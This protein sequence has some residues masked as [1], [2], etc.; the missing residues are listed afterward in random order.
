[1]VDYKSACSRLGLTLP[2]HFQLRC[3][4]ICRHIEDMIGPLKY[5]KIYIADAYLFKTALDGAQAGR[6]SICL[7][8]T[9][10]KPRSSFHLPSI[11]VINNEDV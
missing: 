7:G 5:I 6:D 11:S 1:M 2:M 10:S 9:F 3:F 8:E 4:I